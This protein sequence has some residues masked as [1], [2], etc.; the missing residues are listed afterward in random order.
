M[1]GRALGTCTCARL[2]NHER[3]RT[4]SSSTNLHT[5]PPGSLSR[6]SA[7]HAPFGPRR[8]QLRL[9]RSHLRA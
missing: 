7:A 6:A 5:E 4:P 9:T 2:G 8:P 3:Y 1:P